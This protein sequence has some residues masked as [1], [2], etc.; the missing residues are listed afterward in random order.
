LKLNGRID[1]S[2]HQSP[3]ALRTLSSRLTTVY[4]TTL[5]RYPT[6]DVGTALTRQFSVISWGR[7][8]DRWQHSFCSR[9]MWWWSS[10]PERNVAFGERSQMMSQGLYDRS[11]RPAPV[12]SVIALPEPVSG[13]N[14]R[15]GIGTRPTTS[16]MQQFRQ[17]SEGIA[18]VVR[19]PRRCVPGRHA[20]P[21]LVKLFRCYSDP[22]FSGQ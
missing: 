16:A 12:C 7:I 15:S 21:Y 5:C 10:Q 18:E 3:Y 8:G 17:L 1:R 13:L 6:L 11:D 2:I 4:A 14:A 19:K 20:S 22:Y 9:W